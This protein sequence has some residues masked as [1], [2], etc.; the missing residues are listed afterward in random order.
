METEDK[1]T[2]PQIPAYFVEDP[3][4][5]MERVYLS[6]GVY[7]EAMRAF[8]VACA[9]VVIVDRARKTFWLTQRRHR[10]MM[11]IW[12]IGGRRYTGEDA[13]TSARRAF[14][15]ETKMELPPERFHFLTIYE[16]HWKDREEQPQ[17]AG[18]HTLAYLFTV[19]LS[20]G[21]RAQ[22]S[23]SLDAEEYTEGSGLTE[24]TREDMVAKNIHPAILDAYDRIFS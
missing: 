21:E 4:H 5:T 2:N 13:V 11:G 12:W 24:F 1:K 8:I 18:S 17:N 19:E 20:E 16:Y 10:P 22:I 15:R 7:A 3:S 14:A 23:R 6:T 9:D